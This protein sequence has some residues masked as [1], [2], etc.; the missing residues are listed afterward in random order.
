M[1]Q[2]GCMAAE[3]YMYD[4]DVGKVNQHVDTCSLNA[5]PG[6]RAPLAIPFQATPALVNNTGDPH[7]PLIEHTRRS[8]G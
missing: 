5:H 8:K 7:F 4:C 2:G 3:R 6:G 1:Y